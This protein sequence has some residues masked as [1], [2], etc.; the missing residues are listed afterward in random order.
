MISYR[1]K[2]ILVL[3][4]ISVLAVIGAQIYWIK[5]AINLREKNFENQTSEALNEV[6]THLEEK[7]TTIETF[8]TLKLKP[9]EKLILIRKADSTTYDTVRQ[10]LKDYHYQNTMI[11]MKALSVPLPANAEIS[12]KYRYI[13]DTF[14]ADMENKHNKLSSISLADA[15]EVFKGKYSLSEMLEANYALPYIDSILQKALKKNGISSEFQFIVKSVPGDSSIFQYPVNA[16][17]DTTGL[18]FTKTFFDESHFFEPHQLLLVFPNKYRF[19]LAK[20]WVVVVGSALVALALIAAF[21]LAIRTI[22]RQKEIAEIKSDFI[23]NMTHEFKT[24]IANI[25]LAVDT[26]QGALLESNK[27]G[28]LSNFV[29]I[30][31][32]ENERLFQ[33]VE[34]ILQISTLE[35]GSIELNYELLNIHDTIKK[36]A[37]NFE[38]LI[39]NKKGDLK[40]TLNARNPFIYGDE[41]HLVNVLCNLIDNAIKYNDRE[42]IIEINTWDTNEGVMIRIKDNG[43]GMRLADQD[44]IFDKFFR[45]STGNVHNIKGFGL[46]L[47]YVKHMVDAHLGKIWVSSQ[48]NKGSVFNII[49]PSEL[50]LSE[51]GS[52]SKNFNRRR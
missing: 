36:S 52:K 23:N 13:P 18:C 40:L 45:V 30:I 39:K 44:K 12:I 35:K 4:G 21:Y 22:L 41:V 5:N 20:M 28:R 31:D 50:N 15:K 2:I 34:K 7:L 6:I 25:S 19:L 49:L 8:N 14:T 38:L 10:F 3:L 43:V 37:K 47:S 33:N 51:N 46:G 24:P 48:I 16:K 27:N 42:P 29:K 32:D 1:I 11:S 17:I 9:S 26:I